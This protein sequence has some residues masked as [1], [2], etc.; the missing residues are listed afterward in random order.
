MAKTAD[1]GSKR[2]ISLA[3]TEW[4]RWLTDDV[5]ARALEV[6]SGEFEFIERANDALVK[7][8]SAIHGAFLIANEI[9][10]RPDPRMPLRMRAYT[11]LAEEHFGLPV[12]PVVVNILPPR[13]DAPIVACY[14]SEFRGLLA[15][16]DFKI[17]NLWEVDANLVFEQNLMTLLPFVPV[18]R[19]GQTE[20][21]LGKAVRLLRTDETL[22]ELEMFLAFFAS[23]ALKPDRIVEIMRWDMAILRESPWYDEIVK[24]GLQLGLQLGLQQGLQQ[25]LGQGI[26]QGRV[27]MAL[28]ILKHR[29]GDL[30]PNLAY[31]IRRLRAEQLNQLV[32]VALEA[33]ALETVMTLLT[34]LARTNGDG[35]DQAGLS[36][37]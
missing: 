26:E 14:H 35:T 18:L 3:P 33:P 27:E 22:V 19:D 25:G 32:D 17:I 36:Q 24:E 15:H 2:L 9:Q 12:Y 37:S 28:H 29:F 30:A 11:A 6:V 34:R 31:R 23:F 7:V 16:Q 1:I 4:A 20:E 10:F 21:L 8:E 5:T 13:S